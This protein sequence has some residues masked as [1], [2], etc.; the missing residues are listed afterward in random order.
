MTCVPRVSARALAALGCVLLGLNLRDAVQKLYSSEIGTDN[1][2]LTRGAP[3][4]AAWLASVQRSK[5]LS[6][7][8][9]PP[10]PLPKSKKGKKGGKKGA[11]A[12]ADDD[13]DDGT[14]MAPLSSARGSSKKGPRPKR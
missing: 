7:G 14:E 5:G 12:A 6:S 11:V 9:L 2:L 4:N 13:D 3:G 1:E 10:V 8:E